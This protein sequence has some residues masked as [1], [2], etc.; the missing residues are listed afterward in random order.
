MENIKVIE[1]KQE[2]VEVPSLDTY[3][4]PFYKIS[5][6]SQWESAYY[7]TLPRSIDEAK[8]CYNAYKGVVY[9]EYMILKVLLPAE[10]LGENEL[11][12]G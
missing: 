2:V 6:G 5:K 8:A 11:K 1:P 3:Y 9:D 10:Y 12:E 4:L 7:S